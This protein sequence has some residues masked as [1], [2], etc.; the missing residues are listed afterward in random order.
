M[1]HE[2][3]KKKLHIQKIKNCFKRLDGIEFIDIV[4][5]AE[6]KKLS[7]LEQKYFPSIYS[8]DKQSDSKLQKR[9]SGEE[10]VRWIQSQANLKDH[11]EYYVRC[12]G[13]WVHLIVEDMVSGI[14]SLWNL[15][16]HLGNPQSHGFI[17]ID[18]DAKTMIE[19]GS[20]SRDEY[21]YLLDRYT[22]K[23]A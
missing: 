5:M 3:V 23:S 16:T 9:A 22:F 10:L 13:T 4:D 6:N 7:A 1:D 11:K 17:L 21:H 18:E 12:S 20:D 15:P 8:C 2:Y 14:K 19:V